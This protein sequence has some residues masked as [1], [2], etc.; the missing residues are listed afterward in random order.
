MTE[1]LGDLGRLERPV[2]LVHDQGGS[3][4]AYT[5]GAVDI[6]LG[7]TVTCTFTNSKSLS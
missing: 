1:T 3:D 4:V 7:S 6:A 2:G 5:S